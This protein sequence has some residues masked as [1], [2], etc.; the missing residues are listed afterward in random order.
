MT[1]VHPSTPSWEAPP[2]SLVPSVR[3]LMSRAVAAIPSRSSDLI[4]FQRSSRS[5]V[6][7]HSP[8]TRMAMAL[9][10]CSAESD[11][12]TA[13]LQVIAFLQQCS[14]MGGW[15]VT[16]Q[17]RELFAAISSRL[18]QTIWEA[19]IRFSLPMACQCLQFSRVSSFGMYHISSVIL[20]PPVW[21]LKYVIPCDRYS[22]SAFQGSNLR[23]TSCG[24]GGH[25]TT[26]LRLA[27]SLGCGVRRD[28][29]ARGVGAIGA[30][31]RSIQSAEPPLPPQ[32]SL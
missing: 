2:V 11:S 29:T 32:L 9:R 14:P 6:L 8:L 16:F 13:P 30:A 7:K 5:C 12:K 26:Y 19:P 10:L 24:G 31:R 18:C 1:S 3:F 4:S 27:H 15:P 17:N 28:T 21:S 22:T 23:V 25:W 20:N